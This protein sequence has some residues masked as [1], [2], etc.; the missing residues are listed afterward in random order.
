[1]KILK[2]QVN[3]FLKVCQTAKTNV[4]LVKNGAIS[5]KEIGFDSFIFHYIPAFGVAGL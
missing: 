3:A 5:F 2:S 4:G 1:M